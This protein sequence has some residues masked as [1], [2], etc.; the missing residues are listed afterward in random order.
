MMASS[1]L[2]AQKKA[3]LVSLPQPNESGSYFELTSL[4]SPSPPP[5]TDIIL[6]LSGLYAYYILQ[7]LGFRGRMDE[8]WDK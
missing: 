2:L 3:L 4:E 8:G 6:R 7:C 1:E 5:L